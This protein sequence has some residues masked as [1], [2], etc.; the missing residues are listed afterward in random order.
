M[1]EELF[2]DINIVTADQVN[3]QG[4]LYKTKKEKTPL[5]IYFGGRGEEAT[6]IAEYANKI[7]NEWAL[8]FINY[9]GCGSST[10]TQNNEQLFSDATII[11]DYFSN[12]DDI[13]KKNIVVISHSLGTGIAIHLALRRDIKGIILSCPYDKYVT[14]V[15]QDKLPLIPIKFLI[16]E[17]YNSISIAPK[18]KKPVLFLLA[19]DDKTVVRG[20]SMKLFDHWG[21]KDRKISIINDTNHE[22]ITLHDLTWS[23]INIF[24]D[25]SLT[26]DHRSLQST[27]K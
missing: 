18:L 14:G 8:A 25:Y 12:R 15:I 1:Q 26:I 13:D 11:Y 21:S 16:R 20:R 2:E 27:S 10:G 9:R 5:A 4:Y 3:L 7:E 24:L 23:N 17:E 6:N 22:N 19:E